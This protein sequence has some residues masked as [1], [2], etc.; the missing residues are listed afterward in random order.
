MAD[1]HGV[2]QK[3]D[4]GYPVMGGV[5]SSNPVKVLNSEIDPLTGRLL[6]DSTGG[7]GTGTVTEVDTGTGLTG[8]PITTTGTISLDSKLAPLDTLGTAGQIPRVNAGATALEYFTPASGGSVTS[9]SV[10]SANG[11]S[12]SVAN[13]TTTPAITLALGAITPSSINVSGL[14]ASSAVATDASKNLVSVTNT[15]TGNN[16]LATAPSVSGATITTSTVN[17]VTLTTGG[18]TSTF[19]NANGTYSAAG[20]GTVNSANAGSLAYYATTGPAVSG[21]TVLS[22]STSIGAETLTVG[23]SGFGGNVALS[24]NTSGTTT[25]TVAATASGT[26][27]LPSATDTLVGKATTDTLT[28]KT[29]ASTTDTLGGVTMGL[30]SD[31]TGDTYYGNSSKVLTRLPI[32]STGNVLT[33]AGGLPSWAAPA[34]SGTVT[35]VSV[36]TANGFA[37]SSS[38]GATPALTLSTTVTGTLQGNGTAISASKVTL[39]QPATGSTLTIVDG[40]TLTV[41]NTMTLAAGADSQTFTFPASSATVAG[42]G[43]TQTF[44]G[45]DKFNNFID[46]NNAVTVTS[47]AG[48]VPV[49]FRLNTFTNSS[50][51][52]MAI[53]MAT[54]SAVDGQMSIVRIYDFSGVAETIG[55]TNTENSTVSVPTTSNGST[56]LPLTVGFMFNA[57]TTKWRCIALA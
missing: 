14:T 3:D 19:L 32:G 47:N 11:V 54:S 21:S 57:A 29:I 40:K 41:N 18:G 35:A 24:G 12:G 48:T 7:G 8:G 51:A 42:L 50:A 2:L 25:L 52:T 1:V 6:V 16:V 22:T 37:G 53:T 26:L 9:V 44:T 30:G 28:N 36:A 39:T 38:G 5:S 4:N 17:G 27:T 43:T 15:G 56:T 46:V 45:Q 23:V 55:W 10:V 34:T 20:S 31:A 13:P 33:V 49:T